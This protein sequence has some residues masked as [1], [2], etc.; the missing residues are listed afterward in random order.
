MNI[1]WRFF[2]RIEKTGGG[3]IWE[4][5]AMH[6]EYEHFGIILLTIIGSIFTQLQVFSLYSCR[7]V[8]RWNV[9]SVESQF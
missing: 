5:D 2:W 9:V 6:L 3:K 4:L 8:V 7:M 1:L